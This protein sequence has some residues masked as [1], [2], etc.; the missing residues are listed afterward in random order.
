MPD[1][2][3]AHAIVERPLLARARIAFRRWRRP[4]SAPRPVELA[5]SEREIWIVDEARAVWAVPR[6][7]LR[8]VYADDDRVACIF[9]R[10]TFLAMSI[11][12]SPIRDAL[13][14]VATRVVAQN[15]ALRDAR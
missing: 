15:D 9:G 10:S 3:L 8:A 5:L 13:I 11:A 12:S 4:T 1:S 7:A 2:L 14:D 6:R